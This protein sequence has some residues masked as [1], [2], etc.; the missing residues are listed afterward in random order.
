MLHTHRRF[1]GGRPAGE[2]KL[3]ADSGNDGDGFAV[4]RIAL[5]DLGRW[6]R[7]YFTGG[8]VLMEAVL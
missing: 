8:S 1:D 7:F 3:A 4:A 6:N 2:K 5:R